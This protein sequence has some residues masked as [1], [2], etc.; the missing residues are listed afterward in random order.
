[1]KINAL[2]YLIGSMLSKIISKIISDK[3]VIK[4]NLDQW[5]LVVFFFRKIISTKI[6]CGKQNGENF[7]IVKAFKIWRYYLENC[8][9]KVLVFMDYHIFYYFINT[10]KM[11]SKQVC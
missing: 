1:M 5:Q 4:A 3:V 7:I 10:K 8:K 9:H 11:S 2:D 6:L